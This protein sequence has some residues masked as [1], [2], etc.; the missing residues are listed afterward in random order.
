MVCV[1]NKKHYGMDIVCVYLNII[2]LIIVIIQN[3]LST[4][5]FVNYILSS[6]CLKISH[7]CFHT[8]NRAVYVQLTN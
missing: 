6:V 8:I 2:Q 4:Y 7:F 3:V 5:I 1:N